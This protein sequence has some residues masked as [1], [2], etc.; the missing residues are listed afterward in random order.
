MATTKRPALWSPEALDDR[1][2]IWDYYV[3]VAGRHTA[4]KVLR[5]IAE[6]IALIEDHPFAGRARD[7]VR[8]GLRS[9]A[10][11][12]HVVFYRV[13]GETPQ[14]VR[15]LDGRQDIEEKFAAGDEKSPPS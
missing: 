14:I 12:P 8:P 4:E 1:E 11:T 5:E 15:M 3:R 9:F 2:R 6:V 10:A 13:A 7:E